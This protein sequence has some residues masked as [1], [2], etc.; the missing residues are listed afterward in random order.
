[1]TR[2]ERWKPIERALSALEAIVDEVVG[3]PDHLDH[4]RAVGAEEGVHQ[5]CSMAGY[6]LDGDAGVD[7]PP[8]GQC[9]EDWAEASGRLTQLRS[10]RFRDAV[11]EVR[12]AIGPLRPRALKVKD[13]P[14]FARFE[15]GG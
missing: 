2:S 11:G 10:S 15:I 6:A 3:N 4:A 9:R 8:R 14:R 7:P 13:E 1:M 5:A 12:R